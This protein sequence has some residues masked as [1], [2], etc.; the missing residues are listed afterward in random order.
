MNARS[1]LIIALLALML[2]LFVMT[3][4]GQAATAPTVTNLAPATEK[5]SAP[6]RLALDQFSNIYLTDPRVGGI[7][8][9]DRTGKW[10]NTFAIP[11]PQAVAV[12]ASEDLVVSQK[13]KATVYSSAGA[14]KFTLGSATNQFKYANGIAIDPTTGYIYVADSLDD[15]IQVFNSAG[16]PVTTGIAATGKPANSFGSSGNGNGQ[17][18]M[19]TGLTYEKGAK[20]LAVVDTYNGRIQFFDTTTWSFQKSIGVLGAGPL[21]FTSPQAVAFEY[22]R[23]ANQT[24]SRM[25]V[26]DSFQSRVQV[27]DPAGS[28]TYLASIGGYG[29]APGK[30]QL[31]SDGLFD[32]LNSRLIVANG[33][34][35][36]DVYS[37]DGG[38]TPNNPDPTPPASFTVNPTGT[39]STNINSITLNGTVEKG[40]V[41]TLSV[42]TS[43]TVGTVTI[44]PTTT[45]N[46]SAWSATVSSLAAGSNTITVTAYDS[47]LTPSTASVTVIYDPTNT[48]ALTVNAVTTPT[49]TT[50]QVLTGTVETGASGVTVNGAA[51]TITG[52]TWSYTATLVDGLNTFTIVGAKAGKTSATVNTAINLVR[53]APALEV[54]M[55]SDLSV[56]SNQ[57]LSVTGTVSVDANFDKL[58]V[59]GTAV[60]VTNGTFNQPLLLAAGANVVTIAASDK[61]GNVSTITRTITY[62]PTRAQVAITTPATI[63]DRA[64]TTATSIALSGTVASGSSVAVTAVVH[65]SSSSIPVTI[66]GG[67]WSAT[68]PLSSGLNTIQA[69]ITDATS[70]TSSAIVSVT[71]VGANLPLVAITTPAA[72]L[73]TN[74]AT[75]AVS[76]SIG[77]ASVTAALDGTAVPVTFTGTAFSL[78][79]S[80]AAEG[81]HSI[82]VTATDAFG[83]SATTYRSVYYKISTPSIGFTVS[84]G[85]NL[86][87]TATPGSTLYVKGADGTDLITPVVIGIT[88][89]WNITLPSDYDP[90]TM[91]LYVIDTAGNSSRNGDLDSS[92]SV[93][94][95]DALKALRISS[96]LDAPTVTDLLRGDVAPRVNGQ[97]RPDGKINIFDVIVILGK[98]VGL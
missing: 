9:Y 73:A 43:A 97:P 50:S 61:A 18:S 89:T 62:D 79:L 32:N 34:G 70:A 46:T 56:T 98:I 84:A 8:K 91:N 47:A 37:I 90:A 35:T 76:G 6:V 23:D 59:N 60:T 65:G 81:A 92:G 13:T 88:G 75:L 28:G 63:P 10:A 5:L 24:L 16:Q 71:Q 21:S 40:A 96:G 93:A 82:A 22:T 30:L 48:V 66:T 83:N 55:L 26:V 20:Q 1:Y 57:L 11:S 36:L 12:S 45:S 25:Y 85:Q 54:A 7:I 53:T 14:T 94:I 27:I 33:L 87:G 72:D 69:T 86:S 78:N 2:P 31:P 39:I 67:S 15:C 42:N 38:K 77:A 52:T 49:G 19:P 3:A 41:V 51:A 17:F 80:F 44:T 64:V 29:T 95:A 58:L 4:N 68:V 74:T